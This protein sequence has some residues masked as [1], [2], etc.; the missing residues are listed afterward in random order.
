M[1]ISYYHENARTAPHILSVC[2]RGVGWLPINYFITS[3]RMARYNA[4][5]YTWMKTLIILLSYAAG[6][7][8]DGGKKAATAALAREKQ[9][10]KGGRKLDEEEDESSTEPLGVLLAWL[11]SLIH[12]IH[13][14][15]HKWLCCVYFT[16]R[17]PLLWHLWFI[18]DLSII[19][20]TSEM[21]H[22]PSKI[23]AL[24]VEKSRI[25]GT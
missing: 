4:W 5:A 6:V 9:A 18:Y 24:Y 22:S 10:K 19:A 2:R 13:F 12:P 23:F 17:L 16:F 3:S 20:G 14:W 21:V 11:I 7:M 1:L 15:V 25:F 8:K